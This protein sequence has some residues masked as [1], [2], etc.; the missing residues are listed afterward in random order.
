MGISKWGKL[1]RKRRKITTSAAQSGPSIIGAEASS[2]VAT[3]DAASEDE[4][5]TSLVETALLAYS[6][7]DLFG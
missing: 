7:A 2:T 3:D 6:Q 4:T 1:Q 5:Y